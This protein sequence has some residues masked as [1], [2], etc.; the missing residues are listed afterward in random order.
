MYRQ[1]TENFR[2]LPLTNVLNSYL[3]FFLSLD[4][5]NYQKDMLEKSFLQDTIF[6][7]GLLLI[8]KVILNTILSIYSAFKTFCAPLMWPIDYKEKY[9]PWAG[10]LFVFL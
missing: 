3:E 1:E 8:C 10:K 6:L 4:K 9:G 5:R 7:V 2:P